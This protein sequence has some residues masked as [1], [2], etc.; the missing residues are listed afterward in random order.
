MQTGTFCWLVREP[1]ST[2]SSPAASKTLTLL[3]QRLRGIG[4]TEEERHRP[5][6]GPNR[7]AGKENVPRLDT[8]GQG[9]AGA[10]QLSALGFEDQAH[11]LLGSRGQAQPSNRQAD[12][13]AL[14]PPGAYRIRA[15]ADGYQAQEV[16]ELEL[17]VAGRVDLNLKLRPLGDVWEQGRYRS[18]FFPDSEAVLTF[19]GPDVDA[20]RVGTFEATEGNQAALESTVSQVIDPAQIRELP[21]SGRDTYTMGFFFDQEEGTEKLWFIWGAEVV[22]ELERLQP[23]DEGEILD[24]EHKRVL[25]KLFARGAV[26]KN[27]ATRIEDPGYTEVKTSENVLVHLVPLK[28]F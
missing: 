11:R 12:G 20:S 2:R 13:H 18:V 3:S 7:I 16:H 23:S 15:T 22:P 24:P 17:P 27:D 4:G 6:R 28:H 8:Q 26:G 14:L 25:R 1:D 19:F 10:K 5:A 21:F 9:R